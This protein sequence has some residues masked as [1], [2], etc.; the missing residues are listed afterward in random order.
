MMTMM[1]EYAGRFKQDFMRMVAVPAALVFA[2]SGCAGHIKPV[3]VS[4]IPNR[5]YEKVMVIE[6]PSDQAASKNRKYEGLV[7]DGKAKLISPY[8]KDMG[9][10]T[11][12]K[13]KN[14][15]RGMIFHEIKDRDGKTIYTAS[16]PE[17]STN[18]WQEKDGFVTVTIEAPTTDGGGGAG[19]AGGAGGGAGGG[20][21]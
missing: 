4:E 16:P 8:K 21:F 11:P 17:A 3:K 12:E 2:L 13:Y 6:L 10:G 1:K 18:A 15:M 5:Q 20:G 9:S 14:D 19:G 7:F